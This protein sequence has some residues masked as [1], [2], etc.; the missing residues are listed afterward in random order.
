M[1]KLLATLALSAA[2]LVPQMLLAQDHD[3][4]DDHHDDR[5]F[6]DKHHK[7]YHKWD[8]HEDRAWRIYNEQHH[9]KYVDFQAANERDRQAYWGWRHDHSDALLKIDIR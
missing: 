1:K 2:M 4:R 9:R 8:D 3:R 5:G 6:Y 7:D